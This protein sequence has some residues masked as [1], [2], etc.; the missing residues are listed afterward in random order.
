MADDMKKLRRE[1]LREGW[2]IEQGIKHIKCFHP[3][4]GYITMSC[5]PSCRYAAVNA[6][7]DV[8]RLKREH[9]EIE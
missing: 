7:R 1:L 9:G 6:R 4:G 5:T 2:R 3:K 8:E